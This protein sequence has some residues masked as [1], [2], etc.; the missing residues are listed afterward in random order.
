VLV[1]FTV[2]TPLLTGLLIFLLRNQAKNLAWLGSLVTLGLVMAYWT[3]PSAK[4]A[5]NF[6]MDWLPQLGA[7]IHFKFTALGLI[8]TL[9]TVLVFPIL[10]LF[11]ANKSIK[12][13]PTYYGL[14][15]LAQCGLLGVFLAQDGL[16]FYFFWELALIPVY[17]L[18]SM[19]GNEKR[20]AASFKFFIYTFVGSLMML[21]AFVYIYN[22]TPQASFAWSNFTNVALSTTEQYWLFGLI[23]LAFAIKMPI[24]PFHT[25]Q[26]DAY[27]QSN[28]PT[29]IILSA[30]MVKMGLYGA[31][32]W[33][34]PVLPQAA[35]AA[36]F[37][38]MVFAIIGIIYAS[39]IAM[40][41]DDI[42]RLV[43]YSS[44]AHIGLICA[45]IYSNNIIGYQGAVIQMFNHGINILGMWLVVEAVEAK[46]GVRKI[47]QL[48]GLAKN[49][50]VLTIFLVIIAF[51]NVALP[52]TNAFIGEFM[53][54]NAL[55]QKNIWLAVAAGTAVILGAVYTLNM[56]RKVFYGEVNHNTAMVTDID[57]NQK[58][59]LLIVVL[60]ILVLGVNANGLLSMVFDK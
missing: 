8:L 60:F 21:I 32:V 16:L 5:G 14:M 53:M 36:S 46:T 34:N 6:S 50:P 31:I 38:I 59:A 22:K 13:Q 41:Q 3:L 24:F 10:F 2:L 28:T 45:A 9:L 43:A 11:I 25:W 37:A 44:I 30:V 29:T 7:S 58:V 23:F 33:L 49:A 51:A 18:T 15:M 27:E 57:V 54:F 4:Q 52:L 55:F 12:N 56:V 19:W 26:P 35:E 20:N 17:F 39:L 48:G 40:R 42:K 47:S 1:L